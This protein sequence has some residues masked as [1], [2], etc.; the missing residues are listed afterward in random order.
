M[1]TRTRILIRMQTRMRT[2]IQM[3]TPMLTPMLT[4]I[5]TRMLTRTRIQILTRIAATLMAMGLSV[6]TRGAKTVT[7]TMRPSSLGTGTEMAFM[8][9]VGGR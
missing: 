6:L 7:T 2:L 1:L 4:R 9:A 5:L 8:K 3:Q